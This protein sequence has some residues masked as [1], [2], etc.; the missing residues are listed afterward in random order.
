MMKKRILGLLLTLVMV[1]SLVPSVAFAAEIVDSG[2][3][4]DNLTW[5]LDDEGTLT[6]SGTGKMGDYSW[7]NKVPWYN[8]SDSVI[9]VTVE[10]DV[11]SIGDYA[12]KYCSNL[13]SV[14]VPGSVT[15]IGNSAF[16]D[17]SN[18][19]SVTIPDN[20]TSI[21]D[22]AF[23]RCSSLTNVTIGNGVTSIGYA[24]FYDCSNL[25]SVTIGS[26]V[27]YI[28]TYDTE[29]CIEECI[30]VGMFAGCSSLT[31][32]EVAADNANY[33]SQ[34]D[35][36][37]NK[38]MT[39]LIL[40]PQGRTGNVTIPDSV[41]SIRENAFRG[42]S[43]LTSVTIGSGVRHVSTYDIIY[44]GMFDGCSS[45]TNIEVAADN[46]D[47]TSQNG[48]LYNKAM[49]EPILCPQGKTGNVTIPDSVTSIGD[50]A[51]RYC[52][53]LTSVTIPDSVTSI[54]DSAF[55]LCASLTSVTIPGSVTSIGDYAFGWCSS[56]TSV[57]IPNSVTSIGDGAFADCFRLASMAI[58][59]NVTSIGDS[60]FEDCYSL[61]SVA[62]PDSVTSIGGH[63]FQWCDHLT[64][65]TIPS[66]VTSIGECAF[67]G[68]NS[69]KD[70]YYT[71]TKGQWNNI[72][73]VWEYKDEDDYEYDWLDD[74]NEPLKN[75]TI[76]FNSFSLSNSIATIYLG[77]TKT[78]SVTD[79]PINATVKW[80]S[81]NKSVATVSNT[82]KVS[83]LKAGTATITATVTDGNTTKKSTCKVTVTSPKIVQ[84]K[85][86][87]ISNT[88]D[89]I[90]V[91]WNK[92]PAATHYQV[93][94]KVGSGKWKCIKT[95]TSTSLSNTK[96][97]N[98]SK[99]QYK[100]RAIVKVNDKIVNKGAYSDT[101]T[102]YRLTRPTLASGT[103]NIA[104]KKIVVK[105][106][107]NTKASGYQVKYVKGSTTKTVK[108]NGTATLSKTLSKLT[109]G[110]TYKVKVRSYKKVDGK[111]YYSAWS[112]AKS[113][114][115]AK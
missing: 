31:N 79:K 115:V 92:I 40:C 113:V 54:G 20:V 34:N 17:C 82:G 43:N 53:N 75:A 32:I 59:G 37:Y 64:S 76:H 50:Y 95:T 112:T 6:I 86:S 18:L 9:S 27:R 19:T 24:A 39:E 78:L 85:I 28:N 68:C 88:K 74:C 108:V 41:T 44:G 96:L 71:G 8:N 102:M 7:S 104:T 63:S 2:T 33:T 61:V 105:W 97:T 36:L 114:K 11:T 58:P 15:S 72:S 51:F 48:I 22:R 49:T 16:E 55:Y 29:E 67:D 26:G 87:S 4:G 100:V 99:Y 66:S 77:H 12:F 84:A 73:I 98:G 10:D 101:K 52:S 3:C 45:L 110:S 38:D 5:T 70:V 46:A 107:K 30:Y 25:A 47:Y 93:W 14:A 62:I 94:R 1:L 81:S 103:K 21:G 69:L 83:A 106:N 23:Y 90:T 56:L 111:T 60:T 13:T 80:S 109:K 65:V 35:I 57:T 89:G 42:C 91:K